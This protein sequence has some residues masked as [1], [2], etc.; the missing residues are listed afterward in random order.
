MSALHVLDVEKADSKFGST[1]TLCATGEG[2]STPLPEKEPASSFVSRRTEVED[3]NREIQPST[4]SHSPPPSHDFA[5][6]IIR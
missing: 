6:N 3:E 1:T 2:A 4:V 5:S